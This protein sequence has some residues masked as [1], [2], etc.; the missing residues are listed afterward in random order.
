M[1]KYICLPGEDILSVEKKVFPSFVTHQKGVGAGNIEEQQPV[2]QVFVIKMLNPL[3]V[4]GRITADDQHPLLPETS[5][6][7]PEDKGQHVTV[8]VCIQ[9]KGFSNS[10]KEFQFLFCGAGAERDEVHQLHQNVNLLFLMKFLIYLFTY[11]QYPHC[12]E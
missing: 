6:A 7:G 2:P 5:F 1:L 3:Q 10:F 12:R 4:I 11:G 8:F 9:V